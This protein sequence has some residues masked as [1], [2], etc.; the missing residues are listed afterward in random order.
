M[1]TYTE[2]LEK[3]NEELSEAL[4]QMEEFQKDFIKKMIGFSSFVQQV[5]SM[6]R[7]NMISIE[8]DISIEDPTSDHVQYILK[9][10]ILRK[11][12]IESIYKTSNETNRIVQGL[13]DKTKNIYESLLEMYGN[14]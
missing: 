14:I 5:S 11:D 3:R 13:C 6:I 8:S 12:T 10:A 1:G 2:D 4:E 9:E 7:S